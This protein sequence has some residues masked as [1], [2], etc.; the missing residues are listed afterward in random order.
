MSH[1]A[2]PRSGQRS[3]A[4]HHSFSVK[5]LTLALRFFPA[6]GKDTINYP[7]AGGKSAC[8]A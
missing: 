2:Q 5:E 6:V 3:A 1:D 4:A 7:T 8:A